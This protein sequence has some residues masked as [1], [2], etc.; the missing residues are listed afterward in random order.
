MVEAL[1]P[2]FKVSISLRSGLK[3]YPEEVEQAYSKMAPVKGMCVFTVSG[4]QGV[5]KSK[6]L[7][8]VIQPNLD[9]FREFD[10]VNL[11]SVIKERF[12]NATQT[13]PVYKRLKALQIFHQ[14]FLHRQYVSTGCQAQE[15]FRTCAAA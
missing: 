9:D 12:D 3:I 14:G 2:D 8:A 4:M 13:L 7:W 15:L 1:T 6:V 5:K 10:E 11:R